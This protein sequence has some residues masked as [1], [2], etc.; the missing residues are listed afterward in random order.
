V[1][2]LAAED[3][4]IAIAAKRDSTAMKTIS[5]LTLVFLPGTFVAVGPLHWSPK[6]ILLTAKESPYLALAFSISKVPR[7]LTPALMCR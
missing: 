6:K 4:K 5:V 7:W 3:S 1:N 2:I